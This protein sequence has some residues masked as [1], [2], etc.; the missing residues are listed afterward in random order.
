MR[1]IVGS[2]QPLA[3]PLLAVLLELLGTGPGLH[4]SASASPIENTPS[5]S[6]LGQQ[7]AHFG[8][9]VAG[10]GDV[11]GDGFADF[12]VGA[13][14]YDNGQSDEGGAWLYHGGEAGADTTADW[15]GEGNSANAYFGY[16]VAG[17]GDVNDDGFADVLIGIPGQN[18]ARVYLGGP[19]GL[20]SSPAWTANG[21]GSFGLAVAGAGDINGDGFD[22]VVI[23]ALNDSNG[24][25]G[26][27]RAFVYHGSA[28]GLGTVPAWTGEGE[29]AG[30]RFGFSV[31]SAGDVNGDGF[32]DVVIGAAE[33]THGEV[34]EGRAFVFHGSPTGLGPIAAWTA[35]SDQPDTYFGFSV[36]SAGDVNGDGFGD[37]IVGATW[38]DAGTAPDDGQAYVYLGSATGLALAP[39]WTIS[40][41][42]EELGFS[43]GTAGDVNGDGYADVIVGSPHHED[44]DYA[45]GAA[46]VFLGSASGLSPAADW[47]AQ[48]NMPEPHFGQAVAGAGDVNGDGADDVVI[49]A[50]FSHCPLPPPWPPCGPVPGYAVVHQGIRA[51]AAAPGE[52]PPAALLQLAVEPNPTA[53]PTSIRYTMATPG[54]VELRAYDSQGRAVA[55][56]IRNPVGA[57]NHDLLWSGSNDHGR[58]LASGTYF[59]RI[60][61]EGRDT[62]ARKI[63]IVH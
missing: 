6:L 27:G 20:S 63:V 34:D 32:A 16:A 2:R 59:L 56:L 15:T 44:P 54:V 46:F 10:A 60:T 36:G 47:S 19:G 25:V 26:E 37:V 33:Y 24:Q 51:A 14:L 28:A 22:D 52:S 53:G 12:L 61:V 40:G 41:R 49:G 48:G 62:L 45:E 43:V 55:T 21:S 50:P 42:H 18:R 23:G 5:W 29:Q 57:G 3:V 35:E 11:N 13:D 58:P 1:R 30:A 7:A 31:G 8:F 9:S 17:A 38:F 4:R 39:A